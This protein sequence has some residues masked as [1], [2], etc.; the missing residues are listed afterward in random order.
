MSL[1][2]TTR[3]ELM[4][5]KG[6]WPEICQRTGLSYWWLIKFAQG[7]IDDPGV[8]KLEKLQEHFDANPRVLK[9]PVESA[10]A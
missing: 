7:R 10:A 1:I 3:S 2:N 4:A 9:K 5:R 6:D 8:L